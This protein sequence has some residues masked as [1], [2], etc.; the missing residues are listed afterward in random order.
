MHTALIISIG[1]RVEIIFEYIILNRRSL[2]IHPFNGL[3]TTKPSFVKI[4]YINEAVV[5]PSDKYSA[6]SECYE[7]MQQPI[8]EQTSSLSYL[9]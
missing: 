1:F 6:A 7:L 2:L 4:L 3:S 5:V 9:L 8:N